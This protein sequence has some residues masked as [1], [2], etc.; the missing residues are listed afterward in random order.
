LNVQANILDNLNT[1]IV[2]PL[3]TQDRAPLPSKR[4]NPVFKVNGQ[5]HIMLTHFIGTVPAQQ[6]SEPVTNL[7]ANFA[8]ITNAL[9]MVFNGF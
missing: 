2:V 4:L 8:E 3:L 7:S 1:R 9:D 6:L 5:E